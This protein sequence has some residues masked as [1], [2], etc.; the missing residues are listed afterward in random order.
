MRSRYTAFA[1][2][3]ADYL[4]RTWHLRT[5]P[6]DVA[7]DDGTVWEGLVVEEAVE[8][9]DAATVTFR[10][11]WRRDAERGVLAERS[12]FVRRGGRWVYVDGDVD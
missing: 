1:L 5:R 11:S 2:G 3:D 4:V 9:G 8:D 7:L 12:R 6:E 10:A